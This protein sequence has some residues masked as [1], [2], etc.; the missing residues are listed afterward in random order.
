MGRATASADVAVATGPVAAAAAAVVE[1]API[2]AREREP[3]PAP[4]RAPTPRPRRR[5]PACS[6]DSA[7]PSPGCRRVGCAM[8]I[9]PMRMAHTGKMHLPLKVKIR[10][11]VRLCRFPPP[12]EPDLL[13][14][15]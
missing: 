15:G 1:P 12:G 11:K 5:Q 6:R 14:F 13:L 4:A 10:L 8:G 9:L 2:A 7:E 3:I